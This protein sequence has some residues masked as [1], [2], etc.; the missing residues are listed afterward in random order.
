M[1]KE[2]LTLAAAA[3]AAGASL[4]SV[5]LGILGQKGAEFRAAHRQLM[6]EYLEDLGRVIH[7]S[8]ATTHVL[9]KKANHGGNVQ[10]WRERADRATRE[11]GEMRRRARYSLWG[12]DEGLR[13]LSR[14]S[15]W[16]AHNY[17]YPEK[18]E[19]ILDAAESLRS[20]L[21]EAIRSSYK[22]GKPPAQA[23]CRAVQRSAR[24]LR[25]VYAETMRAKLEEQDDDAESL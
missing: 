14:L 16:V 3:V 17:S 5:L 4:C 9:V 25:N 2:E 1:T 12:I 23:K 21:D 6:G 15:S 18:A 8:V 13:D 22:K 20:A 19:K 10:G 24:D 7:E 11:L